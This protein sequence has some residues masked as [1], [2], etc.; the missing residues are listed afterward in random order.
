M[1]TKHKHVNITMQFWCFTTKFFYIT[2]IEGKFGIENNDYVIKHVSC[3][4]H[5]FPCSTDVRIKNNR[6]MGSE[7][8]HWIAF[9]NIDSCYNHNS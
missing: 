6:I 7:D 5:V 8:W 3:T 2:W 1:Y 9:T 4:V